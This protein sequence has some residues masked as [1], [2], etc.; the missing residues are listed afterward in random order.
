[1]R[2]EGERERCEVKPNPGRAELRENHR[3]G[4][5]GQ[6]HSE[7]LRGGSDEAE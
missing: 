2:R 4:V 1:M 7:R 3:D 6:V 5:V